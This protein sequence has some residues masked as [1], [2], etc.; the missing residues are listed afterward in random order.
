M[1][2]RGTMLFFIALLCLGGSLLVQANKGAA[3]IP[4]VIKER[5]GLDW[6]NTPLTVGVPVPAADKNFL[7]P[8]RVLD[9]WGREVPS[10]AILLSSPT[11]TTVPRWW[12][13]TFLGTINRH[14]SLVYRVVPG[15]EKR[16]QPRS[17]VRVEKTTTGYLVENN[18]LKL[19]LSTAQPLV[20]KAWFDTNGKGSFP[21]APLM[22]VPWQ[23]GLRTTTGDYTISNLPEARITLEEEGPLRAVFRITG[24]LSLPEQDGVFTYDCRLVVY[25]ETSYL[26]L[27]VRLINTT[28]QPVTVEEAWVGSTF[29]LKG[30]RLEASAGLD[31]KSPKTAA[32]RGNN[33]AEVQVASATRNRWGGVFPA[34][35]GEAPAGWIALT[36]AENG[37]AIGV[38][39]FRQQYPN[40]L[41]VSGTGEMKIQLLAAAGQVWEAGVAKTHHLTLSF[42][43]AR[44]RER[45]PELAAITN[46][47]PVATVA[48]A[49]LNQTGVL[50]QPL[51]DKAMIAELGPDHQST[52]LLL[53][54]KNWAELLNLFGPLS[55]GQEINPEYWGFFNYGDLPVAFAVPW[56]QAGQYWNNN[57]Y[58]LPYQL[59]CAYL[60]TEEPAF[61]ALGEAA[62]THLQDVDLVNPTAKPRPFPGLEH[63]KDPRSGEVGAVEDFRHYANAGLILGYYLLDNQFG[64]E[65]ALR[66]ADRITLQPGVTFTD[67]RTV[68]AG[69]AALLT[70]YQATGQQ[71]YLDSA[72]ELV[73][74]VLN[75]QQQ[76]EGALP[77]DFIYKT[78]LVTDSLVAYYRVTGDPKV[79]AGIRAAVDY[80]LDHF[81]DEELGLIQNAGGL[82]FTSALD[83]LYR[84]TGEEKYY[85]VNERQIR[86][87]ADQLAVQEPKDVALYYR[88]V[89]TF[90]NGARLRS[91]KK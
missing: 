87:L 5:A 40:G 18:Y 44:D 34:N 75:W 28:G 63:L 1:G 24:P 15:E 46:K 89:F 84:E 81:W 69:I 35:L 66:M 82:L 30:E 14:D 50:A 67:L 58:D 16:V 83:L 8:P 19:E 79:L 77:A 72:A 25:A 29:N 6:K 33:W 32:L 27:A 53:K 70:A 61:L 60:Q 45:L 71:R 43:G 4:V 23:L 74:L 88:N 68:S 51:I 21:D 12:R 48:A 49:W 57:A 37:V 2:K 36:G 31:G 11:A 52:A 7:N 80:S 17:A 65:L 38:K 78:G 90:F 26:R 59:L 10:Q 64:Y 47:P 54:E 91:N 86:V 73:N 55:E 9:Q 22:S 42:Y 20:A 76:Q 39:A 41:Q 3:E 62:L 56:A 13:I 85:L